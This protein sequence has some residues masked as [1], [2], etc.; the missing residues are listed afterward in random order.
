MTLKER[1]ENA[2]AESK[3][4]PEKPSNDVLL[5][6]YALYKQSTVGDI[7]VDPPGMFDFAGT[8]KYNAWSRLTGTSQDKAM[9]DYITLVGHLK[10]Q[11][12]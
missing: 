2:V 10:A 1:F 4:L 5:E 11:N 6:L 12:S 7:N 3:M 9:E 8:A